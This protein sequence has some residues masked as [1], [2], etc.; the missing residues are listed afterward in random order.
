[1]RV[2]VE[3]L[4]LLDPSNT[5]VLNYSVTHFQHEHICRYHTNAIYAG[6]LKLCE[7]E[8]AMALILKS[9]E[10]CFSLS[11]LHLFCHLQIRQ[12]EHG[13]ASIKHFNCDVN[14]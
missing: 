2:K 7:R 13:T 8:T 6:F 9:H 5:Q 3:A 1:M 11:R 12:I 14:S 10:I 4:A